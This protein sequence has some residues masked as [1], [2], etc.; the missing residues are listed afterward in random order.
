MVPLDMVTVETLSLRVVLTGSK[1]AFDQEALQITGKLAA[2]LL[3]PP[4]AINLEIVRHHRLSPTITVVVSV[5]IPALANASRTAPDDALVSP[6]TNPLLTSPRTHLAELEHLLG[7]PIEAVSKQGIARQVIADDSPTA[8]AVLAAAP[9]TNLAA[10][11]DGAAGKG[12][13]GGTV[14]AILLV[15]FGGAFLLV[16]YFYHRRQMQRR[17]PPPHLVQLTT[18]SVHH[19]LQ[20]SN[21]VPD[22]EDNAPHGDGGYDERPLEGIPSTI[23]PNRQSARGADDEVKD[24]HASEF[25]EVWRVG[26]T[27]SREAEERRGSAKATDK[28]EAGDDSSDGEDIG[29]ASRDTAT[30]GNGAA[31]HV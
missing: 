3:V 25:G 7:M 30:N 16:G 9:A 6:R 1:E 26:E 15:L 27:G 8:L 5:T 23:N 18:P 12:D 22:D 14:A 17:R 31:T 2:A 20:K 29:A 24:G 21:I 11:P 13:G 19:D 28:G 10:Y 4:S